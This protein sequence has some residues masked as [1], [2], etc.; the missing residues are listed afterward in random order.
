METLDIWR[1]RHEVRVLG[2]ALFEATPL[3]SLD[4]VALMLKE[5]H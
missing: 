1:P 3:V 5:L 4:E 2:A